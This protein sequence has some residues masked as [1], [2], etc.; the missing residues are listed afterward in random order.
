MTDLIPHSLHGNLYII[1]TLDGSLYGIDKKTGKQLW[2][3]KTNPMVNIVQLPA[4]KDSFL[5]LKDPDSTTFIPEISGDSGN[6]FYYDG[7]SGE[8]KRLGIPV[9]QIVNEHSIFIHDKYVF[10]GQKWT[11]VMAIDPKTGKIL[12]T[13]G[14]HLGEKDDISVDSTL[15]N[16]NDA[17]FIGRVYYNLNIWDKQS[18]FLKWNIT[19]GEFIPHLTVSSMDESH[20]LE[21]Q[22]Y[23]KQQES[24][25]NVEIESQIQGD[26]RLQDLKTKNQIQLHFG[27]PL[28]SILDITSTKSGFYSIKKPLKQSTDLT[29]VGEM[30]GHLYVLPNSRHDV[31]ASGSHSQ[32]ISLK[33]QSLDLIKCHVGSPI[34]PSCLVGYYNSPLLI[35]SHSSFNFL[36]FY[37]TLFLSVFIGLSLLFWFFKLSRLSKKVFMESIALKLELEMSKEQNQNDQEGLKAIQVTDTILG[38]G[39]HG[40]IVYLGYFES[41]KVAVKRLLLEFHDIANHEV[42]ILQESD[43]HPNVIRYYYK[44]LHQGFMYLVLELC[45]ASLYDL[46]EDSKCQ[47]LKEILNSKMAIHQILSGMH[48]LHTLKIV[49]RDIKP[50]VRVFK[51]KLL[52]FHEN[53]TF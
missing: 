6:L 33:S 22:E 46:M 10:T 17:L 20:Q 39:S 11:L 14:S 8:M 9:N 48:H 45:P 26:V 18:S 27:S 35:S 38:T 49:H 2:T 29:F 34:F 52:I 7:E 36:Y 13:F 47:N 31:L 30:N 43:Y 19:F 41:R 25:W 32:L 5:S 16:M 40:T 44:E 50:Q 15:A 53:R 21:L 23:L 42:R 12:K 3:I 28:V 4:S 1:N 51:M 24:N 37:M